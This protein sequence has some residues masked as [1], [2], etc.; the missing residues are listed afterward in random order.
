MRRTVVFVV[1]VV[2]HVEGREEEREGERERDREKGRYIGEERHASVLEWVYCEDSAP[3][4]EREG[5][6]QIRWY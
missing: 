4:L 1:V 3:R 5:G 6:R 2:A